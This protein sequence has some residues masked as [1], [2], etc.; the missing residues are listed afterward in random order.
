[1]QRKKGSKAKPPNHPILLYQIRNF[2]LLTFPWT[3]ILLRIVD[4]QSGGTSVGMLYSLFLAFCLVCGVCM[5][6]CLRQ[7][8]GQVHG[9]TGPQTTNYRLRTAGDERAGLDAYDVSLRRVV[10]CF[11]ALCFVLRTLRF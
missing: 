8:W 11:C 5:C 9:P 6:V 10:S 2:F 3:I 1:M 4:G 7:R